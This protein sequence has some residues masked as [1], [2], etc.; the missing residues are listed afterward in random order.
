MVTRVKGYIDAGTCGSV[1]FSD[2]SASECG[3]SATSYFKEFTY[4][5]KRV[6]VTNNVSLF[7]S[8]RAHLRVNIAVRSPT[9]LLSTTSCRQTRM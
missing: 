7:S 5:N 1:T 9:I 2:Y 8:F 6:L 4:N 3:D